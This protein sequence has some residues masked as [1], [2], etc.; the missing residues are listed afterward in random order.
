MIGYEPDALTDQDAPRGV[1]I[2]IDPIL[3]QKTHSIGYLNTLSQKS[4]A[5]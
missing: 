3:G 5:A 4:V 2:K 1:F